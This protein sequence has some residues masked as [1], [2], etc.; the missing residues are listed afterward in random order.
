MITKEGIDEMTRCAENAE[1]LTDFSVETAQRVVMDTLRREGPL[2]GET[3]VIYCR[4]AGLVPHDDRAF[5]AVFAGLSKNGIIKKIGYGPRYRGH[6]T[7]GAIVWALN[8]G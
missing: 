6:G 3:L 4:E 7:A 2:T 8:G 5:G 1:E